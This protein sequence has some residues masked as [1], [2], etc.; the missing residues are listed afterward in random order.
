VV[1]T[2]VAAYAGSRLGLLS[3]VPGDGGN[4]VKAELQMPQL[5]RKGTGD[6]LLMPVSAQKTSDMLWG[7]EQTHEDLRI[8]YHADMGCAALTVHA[9][10][11]GEARSL[12][13]M[14][15]ALVEEYNACPKKAL[16]GY[17]RCLY[18]LYKARV[19]LRRAMLLGQFDENARSTLR[20]EMREKWRARRT[21]YKT[22]ARER[23]RPKACLRVSDFLDAIHAVGGRFWKETDT[24]THVDCIP[25]LAVLWQMN[26]ELRYDMCIDPSVK[27]DTRVLSFG[28]DAAINVKPREG[29]PELQ[30]NVEF[31]S[32]NMENVGLES[33]V[34]V[35]EVSLGNQSVTLVS[36]T[37]MDAC[38]SVDDVVDQVYAGQWLA[39]LNTR[40]IL[41]QREAWYVIRR[42][43]QAR[44]HMRLQSAPASKR[45]GHPRPGEEPEA[46]LQIGS[47]LTH[48]P[49]GDHL[50]HD[51]F[52]KTKKNTA[53]RGHTQEHWTL[54]QPSCCPCFQPSSNMC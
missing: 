44:A 54:K 26:L 37:M 7:T 27:G 4:K 53:T 39:V 19:E 2:A 49:R 31:K 11:C 42:L 29:G 17:M 16:V 13:C 51:H 35:V 48:L 3:F 20:D 43:E 47:V 25:Q 5:A 24:A 14:Q 33:Q 30:L 22:E 40:G 12:R 23:Q 34:G 21:V 15:H 6:Y 28:A 36:L 52:L 38:K 1:S 32:S 18:G 9:V 41:A 50:F 8:E 45:R 46:T 10:K